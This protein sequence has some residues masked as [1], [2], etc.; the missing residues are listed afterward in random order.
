[1]KNNCTLTTKTELFSFQLVCAFI[2]VVCS[3][4]LTGNYTEYNRFLY[5]TLL[6]LM[7]TIS[8]QAWGFFIGS[9]MPIKVRLLTPIPATNPSNANS[10]SFHYRLLYSSVQS[11][12]CYFLFLDFVRATLIL[13]QCFN[14]C[15]ISATSG[16]VFTVY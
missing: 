7:A 16:L 12:R 8:A 2:Y 10:S 6:C 13:R 14:G 5:F 3:Y 4:F 1:M 9:T 15:G 11:L